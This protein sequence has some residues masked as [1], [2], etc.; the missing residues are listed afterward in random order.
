MA[1]YRTMAATARQAAAIGRTRARSMP[2]N[3][4]SPLMLE[5]D[6]HDA[7]AALWEALADDLAAF[8]EQIAPPDEA[9]L[10]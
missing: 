9:T 10:L 2:D 5:A 4:R 6:I 7:D 1:Y 8:G 3:E